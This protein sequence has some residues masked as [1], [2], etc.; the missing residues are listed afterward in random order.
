[1][2]QGECQMKG[3][4]R[5]RG[6]SW[7]LRVFLGYDPVSGK[8]RYATR[9]VRGGKREAQRVL[10]E[11]VTEAE[12]GLSTRTPATVGELIEA[13]FEFATPDFSPKTVKETRGYI[14][15]SLMPTLGARPL[16][17]LK[18]AELDAFYRKLQVSGG[19][20]G[21]P[22]APATVRRIHGILRRALGQGLKWGWIG[23]NPAAATTPPRVP[24]SEIK[25]P[26]RADLARVLRRAGE[27]SPDLACFLMLAAAT[28]AR[29]SELV[30]LRWT[31]LDIANATV[32]IARGV[33]F[34][35][36]G[37]VEKDT[38]THSA[39]RVSLDPRTTQIVTDHHQRMKDRAATCRLVLPSDAF[40][41]SHATDGSAPWFPDSVSRSFKRLC[42][43]E[44]MP[45]VRLHDLRHFV[46]TQLLSAGVD[47][48]TVA[49]RLGHRNASTTLNVYA[50]FLEQ[51][52]REAADII[53]N[54]LALEDDGE[55]Q[56][57]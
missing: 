3:F 24:V 6:E 55:R 43:I 48:R 4:M 25:P 7:E 27:E 53:G 35:P 12:R 9:S 54:V 29:R 22:L 19:S 18:P 42:D 21:R 38:K 36:N 51:S 52:D 10:A 13:W 30:A 16:A 44:G 40:V 41:F 37:L 8:Q 28:G 57:Q 33:V 1:M 11:M 14:D 32:S 20:G 5:Q 23:V 17:R 34:G 2:Q 26:D 56:V 47:V 31:D 46:A 50:H 15:R 49:G 45:G 39:R